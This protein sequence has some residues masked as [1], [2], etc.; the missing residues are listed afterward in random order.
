MDEQSLTTLEYGLL[1]L[2]SLAPM[3]GY[4]VHKAFATTPL[5]HFSSSPGAIYPALRRLER[6]G[7][8]QAT[9]DRTTETRPRR[10]YSL[11]EAGNAALEAWLHQQVTREEL[12]R[13]AGAPILRFSVAGGRLSPQEVVIYLEGY[14]RVVEA[15]LEELRGYLPATTRPEAPPHARL[16]LEHGIRGFESELRWADGAIAEITQGDRREQNETSG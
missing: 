5:A 3:S 13:G 11:T 6:R 7:L 10:V 12:V 16:S 1:G 14:R 9:L 8:L 4:D 2:I 15:Y